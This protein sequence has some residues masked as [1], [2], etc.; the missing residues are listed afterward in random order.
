MLGILPNLKKKISFLPEA[1]LCLTNC[2]KDEP[3]WIWDM[4]PGFQARPVGSACFFGKTGTIFRILRKAGQGANCFGFVLVAHGEEV[5]CEES[6][7]CN[8][9]VR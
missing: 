8:R 5:S 9:G 2:L 1:P 3:G 7:V 6:F 4:A